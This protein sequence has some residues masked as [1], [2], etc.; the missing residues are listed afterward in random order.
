MISSLKMV[1]GARV[2][3]PVKLLYLSDG[4]LPTRGIP[5]LLPIAGHVCHFRNSNPQ[6]YRVLTDHPVAI[7]K[8]EFDDDDAEMVKGLDRIGGGRLH[9]L[10]STPSFPPQGPRNSFTPGGFQQ[11]RGGFHQQR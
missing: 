6:P 10:S 7:Q 8:G 1:N 3:V 9:A 11:G 2:Y 4:L 5:S